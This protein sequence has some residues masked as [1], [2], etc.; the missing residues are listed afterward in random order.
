MFWWLRLHFTFIVQY[1]ELLIQLK[2]E[3]VHNDMFG[4][5]LLVIWISFIECN[6]FIDS[7]ILWILNKLPCQLKV[8]YWHFHKLKKSLFYQLY[9]MPDE[10]IIYVLVWAKLPKKTRHAKSFTNIWKQLSVRIIYKHICQKKKSKKFNGITIKHQ[11]DS[12]TKYVNENV[13][14]WEKKMLV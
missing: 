6:F 4:P 1:L 10:R 9:V 3:A 12:N 8:S 13:I 5:N 2:I 7:N 11:L 14:V